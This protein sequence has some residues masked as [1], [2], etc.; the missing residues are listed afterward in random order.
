[1]IEIVPIK[2]F[3]DNYIWCLRRDRHACLVDPGQA[4]PA[5]DYLQQ[6][7]LTLTDILITHHHHDHT[8]G[9]KR[10]TGVFP[11]ARVVGPHNPAVEPVHLRVAQGDAVGLTGLTAKFEVLEVPGH[12]LDHIAFYSLE[13]GLFCGD[14]LFSAGCGRL[15]EGTPAQMLNSLNKL[16]ALP[17]DTPVYCAHEYTRANLQFA[18]QVEPANADL[19]QY[20]HWV[21]SQREHDRPT[22]PSS[23]ELEKAVNPFLRTHVDTVIRQAETHQGQALAGEEQVF[24]A[25]RGW[26]DRF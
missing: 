20:S 23:L 18:S 17:D 12:T 1:M 9:L 21:A 22:L 19:Q 8:G 3:S 11:D 15:F 6:E 25:I 10:L 16:K 26:K 4:E 14:T 13:L 24:A 5:L 7:S 2:A